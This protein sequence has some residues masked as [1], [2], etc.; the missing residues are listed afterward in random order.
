[1][2]LRDIIDR[3]SQ[4]IL[5]AF[6][7]QVIVP[8]VEVP[9]TADLPRMAYLER[10]EQGAKEGEQSVGKVGN[11]RLT[12]AVVSIAG[13]NRDADTSLWTRRTYDDYRPAYLAFIEQVYGFK[14]DKEELAGYHVDH[15]LNRGRAAHDT[16]FLRVE[17]SPS[18]I[19][20]L[21]GSYFERYASRPDLDSNRRSLRKIEYMIA[22]KV[23]GLRPP[24]DRDDRT[25]IGMIATYFAARGHDAREV[26]RAVHDK[27]A[28]AHM[29][30]AP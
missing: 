26:E 7:T 14:P 28:L 5:R 10:E 20:S 3:R 1:M 27:L 16:N 29:D 22:S 30:F 19:N 8:L 25:A 2:K 18:D 21:W 17:A 13:P 12:S 6:E 11:K 4:A 23:A 24:L 15:L 9:S